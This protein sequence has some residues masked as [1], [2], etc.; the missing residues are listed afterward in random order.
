MCK[1][2]QS[3][4]GILYFCRKIDMKRL[5][6][7]INWV[8]LLLFAVACDPGG[9]GNVAAVVE[10][11]AVDSL[12]DA[13]GRDA[14]RLVVSE[15][16]RQSKLYTTEYQIHKIILYSDE[17]R[18]GGKF[19]DIPKPGTRKV[20]IPIDVTL[21]AYVDFSGFSARNVLVA[22]SMCIVTLPDPKVDVTASRVDYSK[23]RQYVSMA[24]SRFNDEEISRLTAQGEDSIVSHIGDLGIIEQCRKDCARIL[25]PIMVKMGYEPQNVMIR[26]RKDYSDDEIHRLTRFDRPERG[27]LK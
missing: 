17:A 23:T 27:N 15:V 12:Q 2:K 20:A 6:L 25:V 19:L 18:I 3:F 7:S 9:P 5:Y 1:G 21:K 10:G 24:R 8:L 16:R 26:F 11:G 4:K 22:D 14:Q 13:G